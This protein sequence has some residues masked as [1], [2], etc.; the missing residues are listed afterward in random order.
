MAGKEQ[1]FLEDLAVITGSTILKND[2]MVDGI[3]KVKLEHFGSA[4]KVIISEFKTQFIKGSGT[5]EEVERHKEVIKA[6]I[7]QEPSKHFKKIMSDRL[8]KLNQLQATIYVGGASEV[9]QGE[10][11]DLIVDSLNSA[12]AA[13]EHGILPG[14]GTAMYHA[15]KLLPVY[16]SIEMFEESIGLKI[17]Q[18]SMQLA[19]K[20]I[21]GNSVGED[22]VDH[23]LEEIDKKVTSFH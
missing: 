4:A 10:I 21:I 23:Y 1:D 6:R 9:E 11:R 16:T 22:L 5:E 12:R 19:I 7:E 17:F 2:N 13:L 8:T 14:G 18:E 15:S 20:K 3:E